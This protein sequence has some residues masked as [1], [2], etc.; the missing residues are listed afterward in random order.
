MSDLTGLTLKAA[1][2]GLAG[3]RFSSEEIT[4]A[5]LSAMV[6][7]QLR[8]GEDGRIKTAEVVQGQALFDEPALAAVRQWRY[9]PL[10][11]NGV[12]T[13]FI[14]NVTVMFRLQPAASSKG[15]P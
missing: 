5:H 4:Q 13:E 6:V 7:M 1:L 12:P 8:V 14:V 15:A 2:D 10:L 9:A 11:L 3:K